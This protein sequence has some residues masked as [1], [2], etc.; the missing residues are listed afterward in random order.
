M[1]RAFKSPGLAL[2]T[3]NQKS[4]VFFWIPRPAAV[5]QLMCHQY[6]VIYIYGLYM[7]NIMVIIIMICIMLDNGWWFG[8][9]FYF[10][11]YNI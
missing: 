3:S 10:P 8:I 11:H 7:V 2:I 1:C 5:D 9:L 4:V 6:M